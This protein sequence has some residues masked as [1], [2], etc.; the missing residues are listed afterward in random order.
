MGH[1]LHIVMKLVQGTKVPIY[2]VIVAMTSNNRR[3]LH[4]RFRYWPYHSGSQPCL[5][6]LPLCF[7]LL[8]AGAYPKAVLS[9]SGLCIEE[10]ESKKVKLIPCTLESSYW[11]Y[12][13]LVLRKLSNFYNKKVMVMEVSYP[14]TDKDGDG[15]GNV[16]STMS[17]NQ[18]FNYP[19]TVE[20]QA[21]AV[22]DVVEAVAKVKGAGLGVSA[23]MCI[24]RTGI[25]SRR[26]MFL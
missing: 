9:L 26:R 6:R 5:Y 18:E 20:G 7:Q 2:P 22:R 1:L 25:G 8:L 4:H 16:V 11:Q 12:S 13:R 3:H 24:K 23:R 10:R 14:F 21:I 17:A 19:L 15:F